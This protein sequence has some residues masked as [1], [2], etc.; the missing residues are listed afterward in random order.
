MQHQT[1]SWGGG[2]PLECG[3]GPLRADIFGDNAFAALGGV[4]LVEEA[5][6]DALEA[7]AVGPPAACGGARVGQEKVLE[8]AELLVEDLDLGHE[9]LV[10]GAQLGHLLLGLL[11]T[12]LGL[13][14]RLL[15]GQVVARPV[16]AILL[17]VLVEQCRPLAPPHGTA[18]A[19]AVA[20]VAA[21]LLLL[22]ARCHQ[23]F[24]PLG[25]PLTWH[26]ALGHCL[27]GPQRV[28]FL[29]AWLP[30]L[31]RAE[32]TAAVYVSRSEKLR[33]PPQ[34]VGQ[35]VDKPDGKAFE[36]LGSIPVVEL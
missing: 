14:A 31:W 2:G 6:V 26:A 23:C 1:Q 21:W 10:L 36:D 11:G 34:T 33:P 29:S 35:G 5:Q 25:V 16:D 18:A 15:D 30:R 7:G 24:P 9:R 13:G 4:V 19:V 32:F 27:P 17:A 8:K 20:A 12:L 28:L 3:R 22:L